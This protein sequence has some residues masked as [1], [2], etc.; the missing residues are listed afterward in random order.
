MFVQHSLEDSI[1]NFDKTINLNTLNDVPTGYE[2][3]YNIEE[4]MQILTK[5]KCEIVLG[6]KKKGNSGL[7]GFC[8]VNLCGGVAGIFANEILLLLLLLLF[9]IGSI[10][11]LLIF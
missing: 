4:E 8:F 3:E 2:I 7:Y 6:L 1:V 11:V 5:T 10:F 9:S